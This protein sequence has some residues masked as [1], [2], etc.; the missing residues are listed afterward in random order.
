MRAF[1]QAAATDIFKN[2]ARPGVVWLL[3][4]DAAPHETLIIIHV[5]APSDAF[6]RRLCT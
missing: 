2:A 5:K 6:F 3:V 4:I 1:G